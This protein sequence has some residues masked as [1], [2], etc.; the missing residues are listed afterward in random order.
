MV[1]FIELV[2]YAKDLGGK[3][4]KN[5]VEHQIIKNDKKRTSVY[6]AYFTAIMYFL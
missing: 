3:S 2:Q 6:K 5:L 1:I 4:R